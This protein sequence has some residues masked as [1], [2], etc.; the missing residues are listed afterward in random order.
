MNWL[1]CI[2]WDGDSWWLP[3]S[4]ESRELIAAMM[5][6]PEN[7]SVWL[8]RLA[9][10]LRWDPALLIFAALCERHGDRVTVWELAQRL[11]Q[12]LPDRLARFA[13]GLDVP[14][15]ALAQDPHSLAAYGKLGRRFAKLPLARRLPAAES[16]LVLT[17]PSPPAAW[18]ALWPTI[19]DPEGA[20]LERDPAGGSTGAAVWLPAEPPDYRP[21]VLDLALLARRIGLVADW[22]RRF[23]AAVE[24]AKRAALQQFAYGL[25]HEINNPLAN[26]STRCQFLLRDEPDAIRQQ[27]LQRII[28]QSL[29]AHEMVADL[30][31]YARPPQPLLRDVELREVLRTVISQSL[32]SVRGRG[33]ELV[34]AADAQPLIVRAD[35]SMLI[36]AVR[37][38]LRN[39]IE[40]IGCDGRVLLSCRVDPRAER[41]RQALLTVCDSGP[42]LSDV[43]A[44]HAFD[45]Y[46]SGREA[47]RGLGV[48]LCRVASIAA[49]HGGEVSLSGGAV[50]CTASLRIPLGA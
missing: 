42:G 14:A 7:G 24:S 37:A 8:E 31:F 34:L 50:G 2:R 23:G 19:A 6:S 1:P 4:R 22:E 11:Y 26:I 3:L 13:S 35:R 36:E 48:G 25:S 29:R 16:W 15:S 41:P 33:L 32:D 18:R 12:R 45:P 43:A 17:G 30:M 5:L 28:D 47:G 21:G 27:S 20:A 40:A 38:L 49:L 39:A 10:Q 9:S 46:F 44:A